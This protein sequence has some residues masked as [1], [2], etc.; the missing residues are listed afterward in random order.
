M[1]ISLIL[2]IQTFLG[3]LNSVRDNPLILDNRLNAYAQSHAQ[4][5]ADV[6]GIFHSALPF[7]NAAE[8]VGRGGSE[9]SLFQAFMDSPAHRAAIQNEKFTHVGIGEVTQEG[10]L[11]IV[12]VFVQRETPTTTTTTVAP[13]RTTSTIHAE[14]AKTTIPQS[15]LDLLTKIVELLSSVWR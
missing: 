11:Y 7:A 13:P 8:I 12:A 9:E 10:V 3:L 1:S 4:E 6:G 15:L 14:Q 5:M 2:S